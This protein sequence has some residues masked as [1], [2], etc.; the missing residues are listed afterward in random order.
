LA[1]PRAVTIRATALLIA[2]ALTA[3]NARADLQEAAQ[4]PPDPGAA[5]VAPRPAGPTDVGYPASGHGDAAVLLELTVDADGKVTEARVV[6]GDEPFSSAA[7]EAS[8][9]WRFEPARRAGTAIAARIRFEVRF[10]EPEPEQPPTA[11]PEPA[12]PAAPAPRPGPARDRTP[13]EIVVEGERPEP[14]VTTLRRAE[15]RQLPGAFGDPFRAIEAMPGVTPIISGVPFFFVRGAPPGNVG[16]F[17]DGIRVP[18]LYHIGLGPSVIHPALVERVDLYP[19]GYPAR[20]G[21]FAGGI[22][23]GETTPPLDVVHGEASVRLIDAGA[24]VEAPFAG[25][26]GSALAGGRYSYTA[27]LLTLLQPEVVLD[28]WDYQAR[29]SYELGARDALTLFSFGAFDLLGEK[30]NVGT[31]EERTEVAFS[32]EFHRLDLRY[33]HKATARDSARLAVTLGFDRTRGND[34]EVA[35]R[36]RM[37]GVRS[38]I[39]HR[40]N[41]KL[42]VRAGTDAVLDSYSVAFEERNT[43]EDSTPPG[44]DPGADPDEEDSGVGELESLFPERNEV[45]AGFWADLVLDPEPGVTVTPGLRIDYYA[46]NGAS[47]VGVDP[48][49]SADFAVTDDFRIRHA[50]GIAHQPPAFAIPIP[51]FQIGGLQGGLQRSLQASSGV[52]LDLP[53]DFTASFTVFNNVFLEMTDVFSSANQGGDAVDV[54]DAEQFLQR[55]LGSSVGFEVYLRRPLTKRLGGFLSYTLSRSVRS[56]AR[57]HFPSTFDRTHVLNLAAAYDL[58]RKWRASTRIVYYTGFPAE[59][60]VFGR[61]RSEHP[62]RI[63]AFYRI[64][65]RLEKRWRLGDRGYWAF[66]FE[67]LNAT[68][69]REVI[70]VDCSTFGC[71]YEEIGPV[72]IPSIGVEA[73]F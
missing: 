14:T 56:I 13:I 72:T 26:R 63:P 31:D 10:S 69:N 41:R 54:D 18:L 48:R 57:E 59:E 36:D 12:G 70:D 60:F 55:S 51:G 16:Y 5:I 67:V 27:L 33:D 65:L 43:F 25:G 39:K 50:F 24:L 37:L 29:V 34:D 44:V 23:A 1:E 73:A 9:G 53:S 64:D 20:Y 47:A 35:V 7:L 28:Y 11:A 15:V 42:L 71:R 30:R 49:I 52:E 32:S 66:V 17:L 4:A 61:E 58:G 62:P 3:T 40:E 21:R 6:T 45:A 22:V 38:E 46:S 68:L 8:R 19:G 2:I